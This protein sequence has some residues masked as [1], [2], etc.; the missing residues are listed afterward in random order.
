MEQSLQGDVVRIHQEDKRSAVSVIMPS[1]CKE[2]YQTSWREIFYSTHY[3]IMHK[4]KANQSASHI[5]I[6]S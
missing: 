5:P 1:L 2:V 3:T 6:C 4:S